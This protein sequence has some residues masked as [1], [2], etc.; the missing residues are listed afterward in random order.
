MAR[1]ARCGTSASTTTRATS[2]AGRSTRTGSA[3][4]SS[5]SIHNNGGG[6]TGTET[7]YD[8]T[9]GYEDESQ[10]LAEI[11]NT[12]I[13]RAIRRFYDADWPDRGLRSCNGCKGEN[14]LATSPAVILEIAFMDTRRPDNDALHDPAFKRIVSY[15]IRD[16]LHAW[17]GLHVAPED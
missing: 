12:H 3:P 9:N 14:R 17:A 15:A 1:P 2:I 13:V 4:T 10:R 8:E 5:S 11:L 16:G 7:W 6:G